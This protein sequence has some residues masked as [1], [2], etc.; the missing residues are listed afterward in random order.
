MSD[1]ELRN[2]LCSPVKYCNCLNKTA[3]ETVHL[4]NEAYKNKCFVSVRFLGGMVISKVM[5]A[6]LAPKPA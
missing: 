6:E 1:S 3:P 5:F 4:I 2:K